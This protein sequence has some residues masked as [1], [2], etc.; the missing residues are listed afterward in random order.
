MFNPNPI[1]ANGPPT[2]LKVL[3]PITV[4]YFNISS[5]RVVAVCKVTDSSVSAELFIY[6]ETTNA[7]QK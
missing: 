2:N 6:A 7:L 1:P 4:K 5:N 3:K